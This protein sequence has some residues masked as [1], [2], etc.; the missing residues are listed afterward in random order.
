LTK[1]KKRKL[2]Y[3]EKEID[4]R[5]YQT[6]AGNTFLHKSVAKR[7]KEIQKK[8]GNRARVIPVG[9][10]GPYTLYWRKGTRG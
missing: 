7:R 6:A 2:K 9:P 3:Y 4:G 8:K 1:K 5:I 10:F